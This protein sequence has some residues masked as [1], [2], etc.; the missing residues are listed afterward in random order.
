MILSRLWRTGAAAVFLAALSQPHAALAQAWPS[1]F[2]TLIVPFG[3][4]SASDTI[5]RIIGAKLSEELGQQV[6]IENVGGAGGMVGAS[7][8]AKAAPD[9]YTFL[10]GG[11]DTMAQNQTLYKKPLYNAAT[12]FDPVGLVAEQSLVLVVRKE[13]PVA[14]L[15]EF[16]T[17]VKANQAKMQFASSGAGSASHL[18]CAQ[19]TSLIGANVVHVAYRGSAAALQDLVAGTIDYYCALSAAAVPQ[20][21]AKAVKAIATLT[22]QRSPFFPDLATAREQGMVDLLD[23]YFWSG[24]FLPKGTP[25]EIVT[26]LNAAINKTVDTP[27]VVQRLKES[28]A[29]VTPREKR[30]PEYLKTFLASEIEKWAATIQASGVKLD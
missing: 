22:I 19:I 26:K 14:D 12:D 7:R 3:A 8:A 21:D 6:V 29:S 10:L 18:T 15:K 25:A 1:K 17:Y 30:S 9:G 27:V 20:V 5:A 2:L 24:F 16:G 28:G 13:L 23:S 11:V 4:G